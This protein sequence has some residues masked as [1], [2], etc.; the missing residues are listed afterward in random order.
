[1]KVLI[2]GATGM[3]GQGVLREALRSDAVTTVCTVG[4]STTGIRHPKLREVLHGNLLDL[5]AV[6]DQLTDFDACFF[7]LGSSSAGADETTFTRINYDMP[8]A[9]GQQ[10]ARWNSAMKFVYVSGA[11]TGSSNAMWAKV[12]KRTED[13]L[14]A[15][16]FKAAYMFRPG[17]IQPL[18]GIRSKTPLY[19]AFYVAAAPLLS[20]ARR[21]FPSAVVSTEEIG[22]AM[23]AVVETGYAKQILESADIRSLLNS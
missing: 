9:A 13:A 16:P 1:M 17:V 12:K 3:V 15:M 18:H 5:S 10:L 11:G 8:V 2:F 7:C 4:R 22:Q 21:W 23:I 14:L 6:E 20:A 19:H